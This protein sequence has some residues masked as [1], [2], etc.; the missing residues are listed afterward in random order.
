MKK[1][2][3]MFLLLATG[4]VAFTQTSDK[5]AVKTVLNNYKKAIEKLDTT[6]VVNLFVK[7]SKVFEQAKDE[8][9]IGHYL[10]HHLG[11]ELK[12]F[13]S[14]T[15]SDYKVDVTVTGEYAFSTETYIY[16]IIL[17]KDGKEIKSQ[18]VA[19]SVLKKTKDGW[20]IVQTHS[21]FRKA[22]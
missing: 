20:K 15:F 5:E 19:T 14:F 18:G 6:G 12:D 2:L 1:I 11:P 8:G 7:D 10:E 3:M 21:S 16:T 13:K 9:T 22:K 17:A 4:T